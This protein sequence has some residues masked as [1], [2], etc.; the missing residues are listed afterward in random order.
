MRKPRLQV[1]FEDHASA[2]LDIVD[3]LV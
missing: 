2:D 1:R 3:S